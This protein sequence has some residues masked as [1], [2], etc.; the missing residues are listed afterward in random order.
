M[1]V[2]LVEYSGL[3]KIATSCCTVSCREVSWRALRNWPRKT[4]HV[5]GLTMSRKF[6]FLPLVDDLLKCTNASQKNRACLQ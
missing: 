6:L 5:D 1:I 4:G 2:F 3:D